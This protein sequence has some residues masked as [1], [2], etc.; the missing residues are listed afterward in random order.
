[1]LELLIAPTTS[2]PDAYSQLC[3]DG[4]WSSYPQKHAQWPSRHAHLRV[5]AR[6]TAR[7]EVTTSARGEAKH[8]KTRNVHKSQTNDQNATR[9]TK[10]GRRWTKGGRRVDERWTKGGRTYEQLKERCR[11]EVDERLTKQINQQ[12][13]K[14]T[15]FQRA[16]HQTDQNAHNILEYDTLATYVHEASPI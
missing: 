6:P 15:N 11:H 8:S 5:A 2:T 14:Q 1:M 4:A 9:W 13:N 3:Q 7:I 10:G 12:T 16:N